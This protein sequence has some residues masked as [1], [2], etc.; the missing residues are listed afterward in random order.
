MARGRRRRPLALLLLPLLLS[1]VHC[2]SDGNESVSSRTLLDSWFQVQTTSEQRS[3]GVLRSRAKTRHRHSYVGG[4]SLPTCA[5]QQVCSTAY[6]RLQVSTAQCVCPRGSAGPC[7]RSLLSTDGHSVP[8]VT[9]RQKGALT[10]VKT[11][12]P[13]GALPAC[14]G[15]DWALLAVQNARTGRSNF[16]VVCR[17][18]ADGLL[19]GPLQHRQPY[20]AQV[21]IIRVYGMMC[22]RRSRRA[23]RRSARSAG[24]VRTE[25]PL[26]SLSQL[27]YGK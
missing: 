16:L 11:C 17:C 4:R 18:P 1:T 2:R 21:P 25:T 23:R 14:L 13:S 6:P 3:Y 8:L 22:R 7:S 10:T 26:R 19:E 15:D 20:H 9:D 24:T 27:G 12:E 5:P